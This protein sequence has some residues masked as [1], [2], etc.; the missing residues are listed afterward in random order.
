MKFLKDINKK[1]LLI[2]SSDLKEKIL[3][4]INKIDKLINIKIMSKEEFSKRYFFSYN[5]ETIYY[6]YK[7]YSVTVKN[8]K[9]YLDNIKYALNSNFEDEKLSFLKDMYNDLKNKKLLQF[10]NLFLEYLKTVDIVVLN[11]NK[12]ESFYLNIFD[13]YHAVYQDISNEVNNTNMNIYHFKTIDEECEFVFNEISNLIK[14]GISVNNIKIA[15]L[16][17]EYIPF[18]KR[19]SNLYNI[20]INNLEKNSIA[21][22]VVTKKLLNMIENGVTREEVFQFINTNLDKDIFLSFYKIINKYYFV[23]SL[24]EVLDLIKE[25]LKN[26]NI[27][28]P[29]YKEAIDIIPLNSNLVSIKDHV[30]LMGFNMENIPKTY[31]DI[32]YLTDS[33][34]EN[35]GLFT[36]F[37][38]NKLEHKTV[39]N[40]IKNIYNLI[41]TYKDT[42]P[43]RSYYPSNLIEEL[44]VNVID[45]VSSLNQTANLYNKIK[46]VDK[47]DT[48][49]KY[50]TKSNDTAVLL[51]TYKDIPYLSYSNKFTGIKNNKLNKILLS[52]TSL[53]NYYHCKFRYYIDN[54]LKLNIYEDTF[55]IYI[56]NLFHFI[57][58]KIFESDF[59]F[60]KEFFEYT[61][62][63]EFSK[64]EKFYLNNLKEELKN[65]IEVVKYQHSLSGFNKV[66]LEEEFILNYQDRYIFK[67]I[68]D[69][70]MF[71]EKEGN[72]Y[73]SLIDYKTGIPKTDMTNLIYGIDMQLPIYAYLVTKSNRF[74]NPKIVGF[75]LQ[76]ILHEKTS[77]DPK[78]SM[79]EINK[80]KLK[81]NGYSIN[82][83]YLVNMFDATY[84][85][86]EMIKGMKITSK[87]FSHYTKVIDEDEI[88]KLVSS[89]DLKIKSAFLGIDNM[90]F[91]IDP[92]IIGGKNI[93]CLYCKYKDLCF[94]TGSDYVYLEK[95][96]D[97]SYLKGGE[98]DA[99][100]D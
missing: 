29:V 42:D 40:D 93:G 65:I 97:L 74:S 10:D 33:L 71:K 59:D 31:K 94:K 15:N 28:I 64:K 46:L 26:T 91:T 55:K 37:Y 25:D 58:S 69:K 76:Q 27:N 35:L 70:I 24:K 56:G 75:Y 8:A 77:F 30:F 23:D 60:E 84:Q 39:L 22:T 9:M 68:I 98:E 18:L 48:M 52:Y 5:E 87:G 66:V 89:V 41:I 49:I 72:T 57:L 81:L 32:D 16:T 44:E 88:D 61:M 6:I 43:Y 34:K 51:N 47:L 2:A 21:A 96:Q 7:N 82:S 12:I 14:N 11:K 62:K 19:M 20:K 3:E 99:K 4:E 53:N 79:E 78:K 17:Q 54:I 100:M 85:N 86:S 50:G 38:K 92:K 45:E 13:K 1:T 63:R 67:G 90:D 95:K 36:S 80:D 73:L 83:E